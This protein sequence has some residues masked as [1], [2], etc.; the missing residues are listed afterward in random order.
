[1]LY[2]LFLIRAENKPVAGTALPKETGALSINLRPRFDCIA[3]AVKYGEII[4]FGLSETLVPGVL[5]SLV[6]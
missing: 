1:M 5:A 2:L 3:P 4:C 6:L